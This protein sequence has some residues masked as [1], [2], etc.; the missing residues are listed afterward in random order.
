MCKNY[1]SVQ[2]LI[3]LCFLGDCEKNNGR[4]GCLFGE[5]AKIICKIIKIHLKRR[6]N[7]AKINSTRCS[8]YIR[9]IPI[10]IL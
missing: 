6:Y 9:H 5:M 10:F 7:C 2:K 3:E 8:E 1:S 4:I